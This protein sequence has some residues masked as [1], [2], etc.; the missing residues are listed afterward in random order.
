[1]KRLLRGATCAVLVMAALAV[2]YI[3]VNEVLTPA[4]RAAFAWA[5]SLGDAVAFALAMLLVALPLSAIAAAWSW[6]AGESR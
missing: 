6:W 3:V 2:T 5:L 1:M 4:L